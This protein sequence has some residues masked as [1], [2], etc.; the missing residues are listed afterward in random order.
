M[1]GRG[2][3]G[4]KELSVGKAVGAVVVVAV[5]VAGALVVGENR[6]HAREIRSL[7]EGA[8]ARGQGYELVIHNELLN[9]YSFEVKE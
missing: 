5:L 3:Q 8:E 1:E 9:H 6:L 2:N 7:V 4:V